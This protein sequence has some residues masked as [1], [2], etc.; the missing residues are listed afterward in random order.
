MQQAVMTAP[1]RIEFRDVARPA[2]AANQVLIQV[3]RIGICGSDIHVFHGRH[4]YTS[5]PVV[6]GH[7]VA[8]VVAEVG[9]QVMGLA[10]GDPVTFMPQITCGRCYPCAHGQHHICESL[11]VMGFQAPGAA[12]EFLPVAADQV[13]RVPGHVSLDQIA[14]VEPVA[15]AVHALARAGGVLPGQRVLVLGAG[16][17]G[18]L[19]A[20][21]AHAAGAAVLITDVSEFKL[22]KARACGIDW[23]V[24]TSQEDLRPAIRRYLGPDRADLVL[25]CVGAPETMAQAVAH[26]RPGTTIVVVGV[27]GEP[28][29]VDLARVQNCELGLVGTLMY[30]KPDYEQAIELVAGGKLCLEEMI[31]HRFPF[32]EYRQAYSAIEAA[33][34]RYLKVMIALD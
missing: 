25:E 27:F 33:W 17:I 4:P 21:V 7:E 29:T 2:A 14:M 22:D 8:G 5:Y 31:T 1:G 20:Q 13:L 28:P 15:V 34:G 11:R 16:T 12:Q 32:A 24:N 18:N 26:A 30:Q 3:K 23:A 6:Q 9:D 19:V 10:P